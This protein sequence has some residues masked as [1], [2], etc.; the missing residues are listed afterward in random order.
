MNPLFPLDLFCFSQLV[1][2]SNCRKGVRKIILSFIILIKNSPCNAPNIRGEFIK[3]MR[4]ERLI[5]PSSFAFIR[6]N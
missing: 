1:P 5:P 3:I 2:L 4:R 6:V